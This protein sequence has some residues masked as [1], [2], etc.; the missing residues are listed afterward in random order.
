MRMF[1]I[2]AA[3]LVAAFCHLQTAANA[4]EF[5]TKPVTWVVPFQAGGITDVTA[6]KLAQAMS[7][8]LEQP[9]IIDNRGGAGGEIG[10][11]AVARSAPDGYTLIFGASGTL[12]AAPALRKNLPYS[13]TESFV[14]I[15]AFSETPLLLVINAKRPYK[16]LDQ[17]I[18][19]AKDNPEKLNYGSAGP[20]SAIHLSAELFQQTT[21]TK[22]T[23]VPYKGSAGA[24]VDLLGGSLD[25]MFGYSEDVSRQIESGALIPIATTGPQRL[26]GLPNVPTFAELGY[27][28]MQIAA[29]FG[30]LAPKGV[31]SDVIEKLTDAVEYGVNDPDF[32]AFL[33]KGGSLPIQGVTGPKFTA[34]IGA[35]AIKWKN[36]I[37]R[38]GL[39]PE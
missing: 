30:I 17:L 15:A 35:E 21:S 24:M 4:A 3:L 27:S 28:S 7:K 6:R 38:A 13:P 36:L 2:S 14:P 25:L 33:E 11:G 26:K 10:T 20:G 37:E 12:A 22:L 32:V 8:K 29:W 1:Q 19:F 23:H 16:T 31:P 39:V 34:F 18:K 5:P 9:I